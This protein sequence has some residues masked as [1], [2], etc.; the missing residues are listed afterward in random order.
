MAFDTETRIK[1]D[2]QRRG[3]PRALIYL[4]VLI[5][6]IGY[7]IIIPLLPFYTETLDAGSAALGLLIASFAFMQFLFN[8]I[9]G[10]FSDKVGR[11]PVLIVS[12]LISVV[13]FLIFAVATSILILLLSRIIA[14]LATERSVSRAYI[15]DVSEKED[16]TPSLGK[17]GAFHGLGYIIGP[18]IGGLLSGFG[19]ATAGYAA[20]LLNLLNLFF[21]LVFLPESMTKKLELPEVGSDETPLAIPS[22]GIISR[23]MKS[24]SDTIRIPGLGIIIGVS[25]LVTLAFSSAPVIIPYVGIDFFAF[26]AVE[27]SYFFVYLGAV[28]IILQGVAIRP[29]VRKY[30]EVTL[31]VGGPLLMA[32]AMIM[33]PSIPNLIVFILSLTVIALSTGIVRTVVPGLISKV[34]PEDQQG[35]ILGVGS[36]VESIAAVPGPLVGGFLYEY[37]GLATPFYA[38]AL[39]MV[40]SCGLGFILLR[41]L[42]INQ[43]PK[44]VK[45]GSIE[46]IE[47][48]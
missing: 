37:S 17:A 47:D 31:M 27:I 32:F 25:F 41:R 23:T 5:D 30:N 6:S 18:A 46:Y 20:A 39:L 16:I 11:K 24:I 4:T 22:G 42:S 3:S 44:P 2:M 40:I 45:D 15:V 7:G 14:G 1:Q 48:N 13:S 21:V 26:G 43:T 33:M 35:S 29:L 10:R 36:S 28:Q 19:F 9:M 8:P 12:L 34:S 38:N